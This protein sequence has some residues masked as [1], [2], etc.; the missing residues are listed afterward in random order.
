MA[1]HL[2][3]L[4]EH[5]NCIPILEK[6]LKGE[7]IRDALDLGQVRLDLHSATIPCASIECYDVLDAEMVEIQT[8][9]VE[10]AAFRAWYPN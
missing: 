6:V 2:L 9:L 8:T 3:N 7:G 10:V 5:N 1:R 4:A